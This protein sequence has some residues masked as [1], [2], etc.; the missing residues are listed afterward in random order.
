MSKVK[1]VGAKSTKCVHITDKFVTKSRSTWWFQTWV[2][3]FIAEKRSQW[4]DC[5]LFAKHEDECTERVTSL[6]IRQMDSGSASFVITSLRCLLLSGVGRPCRTVLNFAW[7]QLV[8]W[9][10]TIDTSRRCS[11]NYSAEPTNRWHSR[12]APSPPTPAKLRSCSRPSA[13]FPGR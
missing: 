1:V 10:A 5:I 13:I 12:R 3:V 4:I 8:V 6:C 11:S 9:S 7:V 2:D